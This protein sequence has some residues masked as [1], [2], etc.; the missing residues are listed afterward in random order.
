MQIPTGGHKMSQAV[1]SDD[2]QN[3]VRHGTVSQ[4]LRALLDRTSDPSPLAPA[5]SDA[6]PSRS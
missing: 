4:R 1:V 3:F 2:P 6:F 5:Q